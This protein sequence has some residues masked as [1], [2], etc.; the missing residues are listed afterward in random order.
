MEM[1]GEFEDVSN[2]G[3][4]K[5]R[6]SLVEPVLLDRLLNVD[7]YA[8]MI[9]AHVE[10]FVDELHGFRDIFQELSDI[11]DRETLIKNIKFA[12]QCK[13]EGNILIQASDL[14][15]G[16]VFNTMKSDSSKNKQVNEIW[17][18]LMRILMVFG[19]YN[20]RIWEYYADNN[21]DY[22]ILRLSGYVEKEKKNY[23]NRVIKRDFH[24]ALKKKCI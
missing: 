8:Q 4:E 16:F 7:K 12:G 6:L 1:I 20:I 13:S 17:Q 15:C 14:L 23:C 9:N 2:Y 19:K 3:R 5:R 21:F 10:F 24:L 11:L 18:D 22:K